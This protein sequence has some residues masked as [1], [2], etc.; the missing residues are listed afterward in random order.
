[1]YYKMYQGEYT[2]EQ[3]YLKYRPKGSQE[4][5][6]FK[7]FQSYKNMIT[8]AK[9]LRGMDYKVMTHNNNSGNPYTTFWRLNNKKQ[10]TR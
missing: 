10:R 2:G 5:F 3:Y 9:R 4:N 7:K 6:K 1:M 8:S